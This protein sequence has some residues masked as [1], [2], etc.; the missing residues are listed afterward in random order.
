MRKPNIAIIGGGCAGLS[1]AV[2]L[3]DKGYDVT[4]FEAS[5][6]L[7]GRARTV[8]VEHNSLMNL[9]DNGQHILLGAYRETLALLR[10]VGIAEN[11]AFLRLPLH[12]R[13][14][15]SADKP[16]FLLKSEHLLPAPF[17]LLFGLFGCEGLTLTER[18]SAI[19]FMAQLKLAGYQV[20]EDG[21]LGAYLTDKKQSRKL[22][23]LLWE[24]LCLAALN[25]PIAVASTRIFLNVLRDTFTGSKKNSDFL[26]PKADL[27]KFLANPLAQ[28]IQ[29]KG[30]TVLL[31]QQVR[32]IAANHSEF[33]VSTKENN[34][35]FSHVIVATSPS[36]IAKLLSNFNQLNHVLSQTE[37]FGYQPIYTIYIQYPADIELPNIM[38]G[39]TNKLSQ[40]AF[41]RGQLCG[42]KGLVA[43]VLSGT[44][45]HQQLSHDE[46]ALK[47]ANEL[48][49]TFHHLPKPLWHKV[50][51]E[52]RATFSC[53]PNL[54]RPTHKTNHPNLFLAGDYTYAPY[55]STIEGAVRSG[56]AC[57]KLVEKSN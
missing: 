14:R 53:V 6:H 28:H 27:S 25:T 38:T 41:D 11:E 56:N 7:G 29:A 40:W 12:I 8:L 43:V 44:G 20:A 19:K 4:V 9:L 54:A 57:A 48:H 33:I 45:A 34:T 10:T 49:Q 46:L 30:G 32:K 37:A 35:Q 26:L 2:A 17:N 3:V 55:P 31:N 23:E 39:F 16:E 13:M 51:A 50:I 42:Q 18:A 21:F 15:S 1:A 5:P 52:K 47:V 36:N 22:I 24:P